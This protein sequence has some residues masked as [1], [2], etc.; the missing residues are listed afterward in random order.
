M[1]L[2]IVF[3]I[4][5]ACINLIASAQTVPNGERLKDINPA[6]LIG[7]VLQTGYADTKNIL[8][9]N[10]PIQNIY[11]REFNLGQATCYPAWDTWKG[12]KTYDFTE[13]NKSV[14]WFV[15][16]NM[17]VVAHLLAGQD[18]YFPNWF[19]TNT[20]TAA[21]LDSILEDYIRA[22]ITSNAN[23]NKVEYWNVVNESLWWNGNYYNTNATD[24]GCKLQNMGY[25]PDLSGLTGT[26]VVHTQHPV[27]IR[28][29][30]EYARRH[31]NKKLELRDYGAEFWGDKKTK[32]LYQLAKHLKN[33]GAPLDAVGLQCHFDNA[34][35]YD[36][37]K[38]KQTIQEYKKLG[39]EVYLTEVDFAD[40]QKVWTPAKAEIQREQYKLMIKAA[41][42]GGV[43]W[44]CFWG[45]RDNWNPFWLLDKSP[46]LFANDLTTKPAYYGAQEGLILSKTL[47]NIEMEKD[48]K[49]LHIYPNP[50][51]NNINFI[52]DESLKGNI[53]FKLLNSTGAVLMKKEIISN[54]EPMKMG[55]P[56]N[57][58]AGI[59]FVN[60]SS[61]ISKQDW[62]SKLIIN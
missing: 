19:I 45:V 11:K 3:S 37:S 61:P 54:N 22:T 57:L 48:K 9:A 24:P 5:L 10:T 25:E 6:V 12:F 46:L 20:Y 8:T 59:Y 15:A 32:A 13:F 1:K 39:L 60:V 52:L 53:V 4:C 18:T 34:K 26:D 33:I 40:E 50:A 14:N 47:G 56:D 44:I 17:P 30:F 2:K 55:L 27:Y 29:A 16:N 41:V 42:E 43:K 35:T 21:E 58:S 31:S 7:S 23:S 62:T 49:S 51:K 36:W 38:L 28:K